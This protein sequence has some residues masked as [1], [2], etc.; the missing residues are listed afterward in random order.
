MLSRATAV[1]DLLESFWE[2]RAVRRAVAGVL[3]ATFLGAALAIDLAARGWLPPLSGRLPAN[4][5]R[6]V[7]LAFWL[8]LAF[9]VVSLSFAVARSMSSAAAK[10]LEIF[11]LILLRHSFEEFGRLPEPLVWGP[12]TDAVLRMAA[13]GAGALALFVIIGAYRGVQCHVPMSQ[14]AGD[15]RSF[16]ATKKV[17]ALALLAASGILAVRSALRAVEGVHGGFFESFYALLV[18]ADVL[19]VLISIR[20]SAS[21]S[22]VFRNSG[23]A[24]AGIL[25][26]L[27]LTAPPFAN[28][29]LGVGAGLFS[30]GISAA[31]RRFGH[32][33]EKRRDDATA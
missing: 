2:G 7:E 23:L 18:F 9:E 26:R 25:L 16:I 8:L 20:Y 21:Y 13:N 15:T 1:F 33:P 14:D 27:G 11:S 12:A 5:F 3:V 30:L 32:V 10:Q 28:A 4:H 6:A 24:V 19:V 31:C 17:I 22:V 29:A